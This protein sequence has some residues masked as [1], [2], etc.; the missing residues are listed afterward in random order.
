[1][2][3]SLT[4]AE[5]GEAFALAESQADKDDDPPRASPP[6]PE[7]LS[8]TLSVAIHELEGPA[9]RKELA[10]VGRT[11]ARRCVSE[12]GGLASG[13][14]VVIQFTISAS[15][16]VPVAAV[17]KGLQKRRKLESCL[18]RVMREQR[19]TPPEAAERAVV[20]LAFSG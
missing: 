16:G 9:N 6:K 5:I 20:F 2:W 19:L 12:F 3:N 17:S 1:M 10:K 11:V 13:E 15:G 4:S 7:R 18:A 14:Q 8:T